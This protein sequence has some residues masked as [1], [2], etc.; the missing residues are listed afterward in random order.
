LYEIRT[1]KKDLSERDICSRFIAAAVKRAGGDGMI[2]LREQVNF[3]KGR[4][5]V[6]GKLV[7]RGKAK[8]A[9]HI[10]AGEEWKK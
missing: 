2:Q 4:I 5:I 7:N 3:T 6:R 1:N 8:R 10:P 9:D